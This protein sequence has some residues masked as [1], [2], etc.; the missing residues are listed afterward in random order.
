MKRDLA[1]ADRFSQRRRRNQNR[2]TLAA[3]S[4][5]ALLLLLFAGTRWYVDQGWTLR[6]T[7]TM[8][9]TP[10]NAT[11]TPTVD[12]RATQIAEDRALQQE[13]ALIAL[14]L[15]TPTP[16]I[17][18]TPS[19]T[20][21]ETPTPL[22]TPTETPVAEMTMVISIPSIAGGGPTAPG[23]ITT[24]TDVVPTV[25]PIETPTPIND[26]GNGGDQPATVE[27]SP[28]EAPTATWTPVIAAQEDVLLQAFTLRAA[29]VREGPSTLYALTTTIPGQQR[30]VLRGRDSSGEWIYVC[31]E[32][33]VNGWIRQANL[34]LRDNRLPPSAP[35]NGTPNDARWLLEKQSTAIPLTPVP[36]KTPIPAND[37]PLY[38]QNSAGH[39]RVTNTFLSALRDAW[40]QPAQVS[41]SLSSPVIVVGQS[42]MVASEDLELYNFDKTTGSQRWRHRFDHVIRH[43]VAVHQ[44]Y[45]YVVDTDGNL[46]SF[47]D[48]G[49]AIAVYWWTKLPTQP[50]SAPN[51]QGNLLFIAGMNNRIYA[52]NR[53]NGSIVWS[54]DTP[55]GNLQ[56]PIVGNQLLYA[57]NNSLQAVDIYNNGAVVW[58]RSDIFATVS[59]PP[60]YSQPGVLALAELY[61]ASGNGNIYALDANTGKEIW[62]Y[63]SNERVE[64]LAL[65][66]SNLYASGST[67][68]KAISRSNGAL[69]W[70]YPVNGIVGGPIVGEGRLFFAT[71]SGTVQILDAFQGALT[72][73]FNFSSVAGQPAASEGMIFV[74]GRNGILYA[75]RET[76]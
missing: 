1:S 52:I 27:P 9:A 55:G 50:R 16:T 64:M 37:F 6:A 53:D 60:I 18:P 75:Q 25:S 62:S 61:A 59:A 72:T 38:R 74:P 70:N 23:G 42:V 46:F 41:R 24:P 44:P 63:S 28:T 12:F 4:L 15:D 36:A 76:N 17:T 29:P 65:D 22:V 19:V 39:A 10:R 48:Q 31:C 71:E 47:L 8:T 5:I 54:I 11:L 56:Y 7:A 73:G 34:E 3:I 58:E 14:G 30:L 13:Y 57:G 45:I 2:S 20:P 51:L 68:I 67:F 49:N 43:A 69:L 33:N 26:I 35:S 66:R 40:P 32:Q 21:T